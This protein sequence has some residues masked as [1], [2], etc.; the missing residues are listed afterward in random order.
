MNDKDERPVGTAPRYWVVETLTPKGWMPSL[1]GALTQEAA[2]Y[3]A[4]EACRDEEPT[5]RFR[6]TKYVREE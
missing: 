3:G 2:R 4:L 5:K 1:A 6:V